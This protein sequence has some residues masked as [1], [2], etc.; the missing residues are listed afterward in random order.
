MSDETF[1]KVIKDGAR[2][3]S[4]ALSGKEVILIHHNDCDGLTSGQIAFQMLA[5]EGVTARRFVLEKPHPRI[6]TKIFSE[7]AKPTLILFCDLGSGMLNTIAKLADDR[8]VWI[9][10][11]HAPRG[12]RAARMNLING[13]D[14]GIDGSRVCSA[15]ATVYL[16]AEALNSKNEKLAPLGLLGA[17]GDGQ[18][19]EGINA[20]VAEK[21][22]RFGVK[23]E[24]GEWCFEFGKK[25]LASKLIEALNAFGSFGY[26]QGGVEVALEGLR[27]GITDAWI[28]RAEILQRDFERRLNKLLQ[29][30]S[31]T[32][33]GTHLQWFDLKDLFSGYGVKSVGLAC[34]KLIFEKRCDSPC[35]LAGFQKV[36]N[37]V[38]GVGEIDFGESKFSMRV[39]REM[40]DKIRSGKFPAIYDLLPKVIDRL[41]GFVD[42]CHLHAGA[43]TIACGREQEL[44][45]ELAKELK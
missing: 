24:A 3:F 44:I 9:L 5:A 23:E 26:L 41:G 40:Q 15:S 1:L 12:T 7:V 4:A 11:H 19:V 29:E 34:E 28:A 45:E 8:E 43:A 20:T 38:P 22:A 25:I 33:V 35:Y 6:L 21:A 17:L 30:V 2:K 16:F 36:P 14:H 27:Q 32:Q 31:L 42:A 37:L 18:V 39:T 13:M 10:D